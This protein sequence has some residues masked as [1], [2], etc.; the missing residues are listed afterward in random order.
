M[1]VAEVGGELDGVVDGM[2]S[3]QLVLRK[4]HKIIRLINRYFMFIFSIIMALL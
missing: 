4:R 1:G 2:G 3:R